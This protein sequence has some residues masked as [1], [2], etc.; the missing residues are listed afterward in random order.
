MMR[1]GGVI[2]HH[3]GCVLAIPL[4]LENKAAE[5]VGRRRWKEGAVTGDKGIVWSGSEEMVRCMRNRRGNLTMGSRVACGVLRN[6]VKEEQAEVCQVSEERAEVW[7]DLSGLPLD[8]I[9][10][11]AARTEEMAEF[12]KHGVYVKVP[13]AECRE[14]TGKD[15]IGTRWVDINKGDAE[16]P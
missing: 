9:R 12:G 10:V 15:P 8:P 11:K 3:L 14:K 1:A 6:M 2:K 5:I 16:N 13:I 7:D 4:R